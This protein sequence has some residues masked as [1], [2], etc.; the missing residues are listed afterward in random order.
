MIC[1]M[2][3][4]QIQFVYYLTDNLPKLLCIYGRPLSLVRTG[5]HSPSNGERNSGGPR[6]N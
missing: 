3:Y 2:S 1:V 6:E 5:S 4:S